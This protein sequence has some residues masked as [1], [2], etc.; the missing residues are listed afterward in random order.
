VI[1]QKNTSAAPVS[2]RS[3]DE[4]LISRIRDLAIVDFAALQHGLDDFNARDL[5]AGFAEDAHEAL[6]AAQVRTNELR[7]AMAKLDVGAALL[8]NQRARK[9]GDG[10][11]AGERIATTMRER[12]ALARAMARYDE[13][14]A[15]LW[16]RLLAAERQVG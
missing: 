8:G 10:R 11:T 7:N 5:L 14:S 15:A 2:S 12:A 9:S 16:P 3:S 6:L 4:W 13:V 1:V